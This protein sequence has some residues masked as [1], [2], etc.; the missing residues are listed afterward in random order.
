MDIK[1]IAAPVIGGL[2]GL[3]TNGIAIKMLFRPFHA[4][5]I[6]K[7]TLPFTPGLIPKEQPRI[8][9]AIGKV[10]GDK[11]LDKDTLQKAMASDTLREAFDRKVDRII[12]NLGHEEG[13]VHEFLARKGVA[14]PVDGAVEYVKSHAADYVTQY[15]VEQNIGNTILEY[16]EKE[17][18][19]NL[20]PMVAMVAEPAIRKSHD[21]IALK[22][23]EM[24]CERCPDIISGY[25][26]KEYGVLADK[27]MKEAAVLLWQ[28]KDFF[29]EKVW[30]LYLELLEKKAGRFIER[31]DVSGIVEQKINEFDMQELE[32]LIMEISRKELNALVWI[33]GLLGAVIGFVNLLF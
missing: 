28:K 2:I 18:I 26:G 15:L 25:I 21:S 5:K 16:A 23:D 17:V 20:N 12:E 29:K 9:R 10:I 19:A 11:L 22:L 24:I 1:L 6:G 13:S 30:G 27:P 32:D 14:R 8:A 4:V 3:I 33:G 31:L 7:F